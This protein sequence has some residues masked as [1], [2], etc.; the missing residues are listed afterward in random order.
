MVNFSKYLLSIVVPTKNRAIYALATLKQVLSIQHDNLQL[1]IQ[2][3]SEDT[4]LKELVADFRND[5]RLKYNHTEGNVS[6]SKNF[7][8]AVS[9]AEGEYICII[10]D[11]DGINPEIIEFVAAAKSKGIAAIKPELKAI[12]VWPNCGIFLKNNPKDDGTLFVHHFDGKVNAF[13]TQMELKKLFQH[14]GQAYLDLNLV[15][16]YHGIVK[17]S[18]I[19]DI[20]KRLGSCFGGLSPDIYS[21]VALSCIQERVLTVNYPL[22]ISGIASRSGSADSALGKHTGSLN[23]APHLKGQINYIWAEEVP[24]FYCVE[25]I[26]AD[27][28]LAAAKDLKN[29]I[30]LKNF[31]ISALTAYCLFSH[32]DFR[33]VII[34]HY[35]DYIRNHS[36]KWVKGLILLFMDISRGPLKDFFKKIKHKVFKKRGEINVIP[37]ID[38]ISLAQEELKNYLGY[39]SMNINLVIKELWNTNI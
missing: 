14:G 15:K 22:T 33:K 29:S 17:K 12:Y 1:V 6:F 26:W 31:S 3:N 20:I 37:G 13:S 25:T 23:D 7:E 11:D 35:F 5:K 16:L 19:N 38:N 10:G 28:A 2:D 4:V 24:K 30:L 39:N 36:N 18:I 9:R 34:R 8:I 27:S 32:F 21:A